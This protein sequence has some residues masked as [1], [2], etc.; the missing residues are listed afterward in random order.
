MFCLALLLAAAP[1]LCVASEPSIAASFTSFWNVAQ[2]QPFAQQVQQWDNRIEAPRREL[3]NSVVWEMQNDPRWQIRRQRWL[4]ARFAAYPKLAAS[5]PD[6]VRALQST[7]ATQ[8]IRFRKLFPDASA[9][10]PVEILLAPNFDAKS[11]TLS[12]GTPVLAFAADSLL[13]EQ[14]NLSIVVPHELFHLYHAQHAGISND[15]VM[16]GVALTVPLFE[17]GLATYVS[18]QLSPGHTDGEL[19][20]QNDLGNIPASRLPDI[21]RRFLED[22]QHR[23]ID[24]EHPEVFKRWF[25]AAATP[26]QQGLPNR[27]GYWLGLQLIRYLRRTYTLAQIAAWSPTQADMQVMSALKRISRKQ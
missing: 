24:P 12:D 5:I 23:A 21:A 16:P 13:L 2:G 18:G 3:Y 19:L 11:G 7:I 22:A 14:A 26:Y 10:P 17:E 25:N 4:Q 20:L 6:E 8:S 9:H 1:A 15:G 27:S